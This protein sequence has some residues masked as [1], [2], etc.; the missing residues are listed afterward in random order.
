MQPLQPGLQE[1][2]KSSLHLVWSKRL[3]D[4]DFILHMDDRISGHGYLPVYTGSDTQHICNGLRRNA[5]YKFRLQAHN[6]EG[7]S[8]WSEEVWYETLPDKPGPP[9]RPASKGRL[10]SNSFKVRWD[11]PSDDGG[12]PVT[13]YILEIDDSRGWQTVYRGSDL[14]CICDN[15][16]PGTQYKVRVA[17]TSTGGVSEYSDVCHICT[18]PVNPGQ[19][20]PPRPHGKPKAT[21]IHLKWGWPETDGGSEVTEFEIDMTSPD[22]TTRA[23]YRGHDTECVVASLLPGRPYLFQVRA[24]NRAGAGPWSESLEVVS[25]AGAPD[26]PNAPILLCRGPTVAHVEWECPINNGAIISEFTLQM[27]II[28]TR[29]CLSPP[30][31]NS[32]DLSRSGHHTRSSSMSSDDSLENDEEE[33]DDEDYDEEEEEQPSDEES[34][35]S[36]HEDED[37]DKDGHHKKVHHLR[38]RKKKG[39]RNADSNESD[40]DDDMD[41]AYINT[42][43]YDHETDTNIS[44]NANDDAHITEGIDDSINENAVD[45]L[46]KEPE[47]KTIYTGS[48]SSYDARNLVP[49]TTYL[50]KVCATNSAGSSE[51]SEETEAITPAAP[52]AAVSGLHLRSATAT[53]LTLAWARPVANGENI[54]HYNVDNVG[55]AVVPTPGPDTFFVIDRLKP[56]NLYTLRVQAVN[57]VGPGPFSHPA[58]KMSTRPLPP[59]P[60]RCECVNANHNSLKLKWGDSKS[61]ATADFCHYTLEMEN[62]RNQ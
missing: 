14:E 10:H 34:P 7:K 53:S 11:C 29:K 16:R 12:S 50:F 62:S 54:T 20:A 48:Q 61:A 27:A 28:S 4:I 56:D 38:K 40:S 19:C 35:D 33:V 32:R 36:E 45:E 18:E 13:N 58:T 6:E 52:P 51:W 5:A 44:L 8:P 2:T 37:D 39:T 1:A 60:P 31:S 42:H 46:V 9:L 55:L 59:A 25:G 15:L 30:P 41:E 23:V 21:S 22:N 57:S 17:C 26:Q 47:F 24:H 3:S 43:E 49:A